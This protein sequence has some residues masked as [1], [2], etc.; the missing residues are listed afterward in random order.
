[1]PGFTSSPPGTAQ[2]RGP[3]GG[4]L[5]QLDRSI[6][7]VEAAQLRSIEALRRRSDGLALGLRTA[8]AATGLEPERLE[9]QGVRSGVGGP[10]VPLP[11]GSEADGFELAAAQAQNSLM[12]LTRL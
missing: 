1:M 7:L 11:S 8:I 12:Q 10:F 6:K 5:S 4:R 9:P 3:A 2:D